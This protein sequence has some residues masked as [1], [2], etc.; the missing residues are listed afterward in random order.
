MGRVRSRREGS[1]TSSTSSYLLA[2]LIVIPAAQ[3]GR[4]IKILA[5]RKYDQCSWRSSMLPLEIVLPLSTLPFGRFSFQ[6]Q[7]MVKVD[8]TTD[9]E[10]RAGT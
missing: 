4:L 7:T 10:W 6:G 2:L 3:S 1:L 5:C 8:L 9:A